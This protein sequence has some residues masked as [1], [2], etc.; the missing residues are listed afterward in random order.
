[1][2]CPNNNNSEQFHSLFQTIKEKEEAERRRVCL[3]EE[4]RL[5]FLGLQHNRELPKIFV[6]NDSMK[7]KKAI[8]FVFTQMF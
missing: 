7:H 2:G 4:S 5:T 8:E 3:E 1:M 6:K